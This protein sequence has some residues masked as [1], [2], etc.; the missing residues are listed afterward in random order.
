MPCPTAIGYTRDTHPSAPL[1]LE[2]VTGVS[3]LPVS[4]VGP[5]LTSQDGQPV[6][7]TSL[8]RMTAPERR[9]SLPDAAGRR[10]PGTLNLSGADA[11]QPGA[12]AARRW[13]DPDGARLRHYGARCENNDKN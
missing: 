9:T 7:G 12:A 8:R 10:Q 3:S 2:A 4:Q 1:L 11:T 6:R 13:R 5:S